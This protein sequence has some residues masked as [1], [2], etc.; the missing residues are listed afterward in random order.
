MI[1]KRKIYKKILDWKNTSKGTK[2]LLVEGARRI[3]KSTI[4]E[5]FAKKEYKSYILIDFNDVSN[6]IINA[7]ENY[8]N[9]LDTFFMILSTEYGKTLFNKDSL[10]IFDEIQNY[11]K[12]RQSIKKLVNDGRYDYIETGSLISIKENV[13]DITIPS[14]E[15]NIKMYPMDFEEF[16]WALGE[17]KMIE[18]IKKCYIEKTP[19]IED[20][21]HR[22]MLLFKQYMLVGGMPLVVSSYLTN[23]KSFVSAD[24]E[25]RAILDLY[26]NDINKAYVT[27]RKKVTSIFSQIPSFL[28]SHEKKIIFSKLGSKQASSSY[29]EAFFWLKD[30]MICNVCYNCTDPNVGLSLNE[31]HSF[32]KCYMGDTGLLISHTFSEI[33][34]QENNIYKQILHDNLSINE[35]MFFENIIAQGLVSNGYDLYF[36]TKYSTEKHRNEMEI[37][38]IISN[39]SKVMPKIYP[40]EVKSSKLYKTISLDKFTTVYNKRIGNSIVI[41]TKNLNVDGNKLFIP[42]Y[43][44]FCL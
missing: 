32:V 4:V 17:N 36:F 11:P 6:V 23:N 43:M 37:D 7:F 33:E 21:H 16:C 3:G 39:N 12:A 42:C 40:I 8:L 10:I 9:D 19:L 30:S 34:T 24:I 31:D 27:Y 2:A 41:H 35:G 1:F 28:S 5:E 25:K 22:A 13:K 44:A 29:D 38:F 26:S 14:E 20:F 15:R 18:Y